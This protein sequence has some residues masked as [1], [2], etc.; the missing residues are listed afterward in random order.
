MFSFG[1]PQQQQQQPQ[2]QTSGFGAFSFGT[3]NNPPQSQQQQQQQPQQQTNLFSGFGTGQQQNQNYQQQQQ[4]QQQ[5]TKPLINRYTK[6]NDLPQEVQIQLEQINKVVNQN[7]HDSMKVST[8]EVSKQ[9]ERLKVRY[10]NESVTNSLLRMSQTIDG[11]LDIVKGQIRSEQQRL[12]E[13]AEI[14]N[15]MLDSIQQSLQQSSQNGFGRSGTH[16]A[17]VIHEY[18]MRFIQNARQ[19]FN[20]YKLALQD[21][22]LQVDQLMVSQDGFRNANGSLQS[23]TTT[24][25]CVTSILQQ[26][27]NSLLRLSAQASTT[28]QQLMQYANQ[29]Q[30]YQKNVNSSSRYNAENLEN[31]ETSMKM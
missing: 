26:N 20:S 30:D 28:H 8:S 3:A 23:V 15:R 18:Y 4:Q 19:Q 7:K 29:W 25:E 2:Q 9:L 17:D 10:V 5:Q 21:M 31:I 27:Y 1:Q 13:T 11:Q 6:F 12:A 16:Y 14:S 24:P 22:K